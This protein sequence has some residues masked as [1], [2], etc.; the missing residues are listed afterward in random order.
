MRI[1]LNGISCPFQHFPE[2]RAS[3]IST[4]LSEFLCGTGVMK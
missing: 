3:D 2:I 4:S 1:Q